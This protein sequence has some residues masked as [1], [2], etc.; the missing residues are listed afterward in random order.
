[1]SFLVF[2]ISCGQSDGVAPGTTSSSSVTNKKIFLSAATHN[3]N[4]GGAASADALCAVDANLPSGGGTYKAL[5]A[6]INRQAP[7]TDWPLQASTTYTRSDG[8]TIIGTT[9][10]GRIFT[11]PLT[12]SI[13][14]LNVIVRTGLDI[15]WANNASSNCLDWTSSNAM[16]TGSTGV[17]DQ[18]TSSAIGLLTGLDCSNA[19]KFYC[20]EQ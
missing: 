15:A 10:S 1:M 16:E 6:D 3:G 19:Y 20:V 8:T 11:F 13:S 9:T 12:N 17:A 2:L 14:N 4:F 7:S 18:I 5:I